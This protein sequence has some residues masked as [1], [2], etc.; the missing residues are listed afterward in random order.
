[1]QQAVLEH[2]P[3][4]VVSYR[5]TNRGGDQFTREAYERVRSEIAGT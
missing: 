2:Y 3:D 1:M 4:A 5:F